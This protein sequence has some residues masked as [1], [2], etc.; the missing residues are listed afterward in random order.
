MAIN[1]NLDARTDVDPAAQPIPR[2][3]VGY[4]PQVSD[5][6]SWNANR[7]V[8]VL[9]EQ[10]QNESLATFSHE[11]L[12]KLVAELEGIEHLE[13]PEGP[14]QALLGRILPPGDPVR[15]ALVNR[16]VDSTAQ[17]S[18]FDTS[19][20]ESMPAAERYSPR[21][22][23]TFLLNLYPD[24]WVWA[25]EDEADIV[26]RTAAGGSWREPWMTGGRRQ[27]IE[28]G[29][30]VFLVQAGPG[31]RGIRGA[32]IVH[33]PVYQAEHWDDPSKVGNYVD[34]TWDVLLPEERMIDLSVVQ[35]RVPGYGWTPQKGGV[36]LH[37][38]MAGQLEELWAEHLG[39]GR[40][41]M[42][43]PEPG[44][45][46]E[47]ARRRTLGAEAAQRAV[48]Q[49]V[50]DGWEVVAAHADRPFDA[51]LTRDGENRFL[52]AKAIETAGRPVHLS[53]EE[54]E[55][56]LAHPDE[57]DLA[58]LSDVEFEGGSAV[59]GTG[60]LIIEPARISADDIRPTLYVW[61]R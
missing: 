7:G 42:V 1:I 38:P 32:G 16:A 2:S 11:G 33:T 15:D 56:L 50:A 21:S 43:R 31:N 57:C 61:E 9:E 26:A 39:D 28:S 45:S 6:I 23:R 25:P 30:R 29:D 10:A 48:E 46:S 49:L 37:Q 44:W 24:K 17:V 8:F 55:H 19:D 41:T 20:L 4:D 13:T 36:E 40:P 5:E 27:G 60:Q 34:I 52:L 58:L 51:V 3:F 18:S 54:V 47:D 14:R 35:Q 12:V 53:A 22:R 59:L